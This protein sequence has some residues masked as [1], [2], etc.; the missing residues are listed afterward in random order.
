MYYYII[1]I[2][3]LYNCNEH[4]WSYYYILKNEKSWSDD[5]KIW[6]N[7]FLMQQTTICLFSYMKQ[8]WLVSH[9]RYYIDENKN[10]VSKSLEAHYF[11]VFSLFK[12][13]VFDR[14]LMS[15]ARGSSPV[16]FVTSQS[17]RRQKCNASSGA[18]SQPVVIQ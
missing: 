4:F 13:V 2:I 10:K 15:S 6:K 8:I 7:Y 9:I 1:L 12:S 14:H 18:L 11:S 16:V 5:R 17:A 3:D